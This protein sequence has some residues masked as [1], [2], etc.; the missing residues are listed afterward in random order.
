MAVAAK[1]IQISDDSADGLYQ[2]GL[3]AISAVAEE[4]KTTQTL[5][6]KVSTVEFQKVATDN[7]VFAA[8]DTINTAAGAGTF[9]GIWLIQITDAGVITTKSPSADQVYANEAAAIAALPAV[10]GGNTSVGYITVE[11]NDTASWTANT[12]DLTPASDCV[13]ANFVDTAEVVRTWNTLPGNTGAL[14]NDAGELDDTIFGQPFK[15]GQTSLINA[16]ITANAFYKGFAG[17]VA[18]I[19]KGGTPVNSIGETL[20]LVS[21]KTYQI[22]TVSERVIDYSADVIVDDNSIDHTADVLNID[23][24]N[25]LITFNP[26]Y[27]VT[28]PVTI[29]YD[30]IPLAVIAKA[31]TFSLTQTMDP[32]DITDFV[33]AQANSGYRIFDPGLLTAALELGGFYDLANGWRAQ[34]ESRADIVIE[35]GPDA[36]ALS[37]ARGFFNTMSQNLAGN[38][39][40]VETETLRFSL[41]VPEVFAGNPA[42]NAPFNWYHDNASTLSQAVQIILDGWINGTELDVR[43]LPDGING[44][45]APCIIAEASLSGGVDAMNTFAVTIQNIGVFA[46]VP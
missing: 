2:E 7:L 31:N 28:T 21:G 41:N 29:D 14:A 3:L 27:S 6:W 45:E 26:G 18:R 36:A 17:Y 11:A 20:T 38:V 5:I 34:L 15:S 4:F 10:D 43:Y 12:D 22:D 35:I 16:R 46:P 23:Y 8:A 39:G 44:L 33:T 9:W 19:L 37:W 24:L 30:Y 25:G 13:S 1:K 32:Q 42:L 40:A